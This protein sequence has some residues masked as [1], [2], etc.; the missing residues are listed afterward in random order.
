MGTLDTVFP[1][2]KQKSCFQFSFCSALATLQ[3]R[4][5]SRP[6][7]SVTVSPRRLTEWSEVPAATPA[8]RSLL[9]AAAPGTAPRTGIVS[10]DQPAAQREQPVEHTRETAPQG[11]PA[12]T[13]SA[14]P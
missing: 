7:A 13:V 1:I 9:T 4:A 5:V 12:P 10:T 8:G 3:V 11:L 14:P 2:C 6:A